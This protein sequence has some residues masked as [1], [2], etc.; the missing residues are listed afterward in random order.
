MKLPCIR[1]YWKRDDIYHDSPIALKDWFDELRRYLHFVNNDTL[2]P[3]GTP[4]YNRLGKVQPAIDSFQEA[5]QSVYNPS[6]NVS[7][8]E[9]MIPFK[10]RSTLKQYMPLKPVKR[11]IKVWALADATNG[12]I[13]NFQ[14]Y[15]GRQGDSVER[16]LGAN[17]VKTLTKP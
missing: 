10:G 1:D 2:H 6:Q 3:R 16:G 8:D 14:V 9:A 4:E 17:I 11:G 13:C 12:Y 7:V 5:F 15:T